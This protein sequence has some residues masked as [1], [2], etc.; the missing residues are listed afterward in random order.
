MTTVPTMAFSIT[1]EGR[2]VEFINTCIKKGYVRDSKEF[3]DKAGAFL[4]WGIGVLERGEQIATFDE[5]AMSIT[6]MP[7]ALVPIQDEKPNITKPNPMS[8][9]VDNTKK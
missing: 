7:V 1:L 8:L 2:G 6:V 5:K 9:V 4:D 3:F